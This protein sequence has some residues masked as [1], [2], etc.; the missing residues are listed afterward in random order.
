MRRYLHI[1]IAVF[2]IIA[3]MCGCRTQYVPVEVV[4]TETVHHHDTIRQT[5][6]IRNEKE[7]IIREARPEDSAMIARLGIRL[8][9]NERLLILLQKELSDAKSNSYESHNKDSVRVDSIQVPYP[10]PAQLSRWQSFCCDYGKVMLGGTV[11]MVVALIICVFIIIR[12]RK[13]ST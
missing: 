8:Q 6:S 3:L 4:R 1:I 5:D 11:V 9:D 7:T 10:V 12:R 13:R 2:A